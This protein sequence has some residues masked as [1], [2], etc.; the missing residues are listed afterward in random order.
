MCAS[1]QTNANILD[2]RTHSFKVSCA[3]F[4]DVSSEKHGFKIMAFV[5]TVLAFSVPVEPFI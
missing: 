4:S 5:S 3:D 2:D 1:Y